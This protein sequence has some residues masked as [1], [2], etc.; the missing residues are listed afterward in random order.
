MQCAFVFVLLQ[1]G[2]AGIIAGCFDREGQKGTALGP[3]WQSM[4][5]STPDEGTS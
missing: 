3:Y 1:H 4:K 5:V 2:H